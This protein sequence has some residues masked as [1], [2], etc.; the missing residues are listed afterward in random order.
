MRGNGAGYTSPAEMSR[1]NVRTERVHSTSRGPIRRGSGGQA[2]VEF[3]LVFGLFLVLFFPII[4]AGLWSIE[5][6]AAV[7][8]TEQGV[9][10]ALGA[11]GSPG[12]LTTSERLV[13]AAVAPQLKTAIFGA[14]V[15]DWWA[16]NSAPMWA[17]FTGC[18]SSTDVVGRMGTGHVVV[19]AVNNGDGTVTVAIAGCAPS[20]V[21]PSF[22][23]G[24]C[25]GGALPIYERATSRVGTFPG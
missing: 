11:S 9:G 16:I 20:G 15:D 8:A 14:T 3:A 21:P 6:D 13:Y 7:S 1:A 4:D 17:G 12:S 5:S 22:S 23:I 2:A 19:C 24:K 10:V 25:G 18:P